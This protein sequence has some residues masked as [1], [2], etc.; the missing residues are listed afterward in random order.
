[1]LVLVT[2]ETDFIMI[3]PFCFLSDHLWRTCCLV[4]AENLTQRCSA[5]HGE[6]NV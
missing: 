3:H 2:L 5:N 6:K 4:M 1:M